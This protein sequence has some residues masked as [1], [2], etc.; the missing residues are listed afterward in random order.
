MTNNIYFIAADYVNGISIYKSLKA[1]KVSG[2]IIVFNTSGRNMA[3]KVFPELPIVNGITDGE[4]LMNY[5]LSFDKRINKYLFLTH[6]MFHATLW[7]NRERL[8][9]HNVIYHIGNQN[10][11]LI[12]DKRKFLGNLKENSDVPVPTSYSLKHVESIKFPV[13]VKPKSSFFGDKKTSLEKAVIETKTELENYFQK[14]EKHGADKDD[15]EIQELLSTQTRDNISVSG[16][17]ENGF[18]RFYQTQKILQHPPKRGNGDVV[19]LMQLNPILEKHVLEV[20]KI[21]DYQGPFEAE[22][23]KEKKGS[24]YKLIEINPRFW[25]QHGL[26]EQLSGHLLVARYIGVSAMAPVTKYQ[27]W[28]YTTIVPI[29]LAKLRLNYIPYLLRRDVYKPISFTQSGKFLLKYLKQVVF[30]SRV[31]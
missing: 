1:L 29:Q 8:K 5:L 22:F 15:V 11:E 12:L 6:E 9:T 18:H 13:F 19:K 24:Q 21:L 30:I 10:P 2:E 31:I 20:M 23:V 16:W 25:M 14:V 27:Y 7:E 4:K 17:Y 3:G 28:M 26:I